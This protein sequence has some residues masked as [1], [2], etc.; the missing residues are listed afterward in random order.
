MGFRSELAE[1]RADIHREFR[2]PAFF[3]DD[4]AAPSW[5]PID[6]R[7]MTKG[8]DPIAHMLG[9]FEIRQDNPMIIFRLS[10]APLVSEGSL[11]ACSYGIFRLM[12][13]PQSDSYGWARVLT[14][15]LRGSP[16]VQ[17]PTIPPDY[18]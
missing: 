12:H 15:R 2:M 9:I 3:A 5:S 10:D 6:V 13:A 16:P 8:D 17:P 11:I 1:G 7:V 14:E 4:G 18:E